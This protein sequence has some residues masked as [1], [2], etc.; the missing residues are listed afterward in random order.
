MKH[1]SRAKESGSS[2]IIRHDDCSSRIQ[3]ELHIVCVSCTRDV[4]ERIVEIVI[5]Q[6]FLELLNEIQNSAV[7]I[8]WRPRVI[9]KG[10]LCRNVAVVDLLRKDVLL[11]QKE[12]DGSIGKGSVVADRAEELQ[13]LGH[14]VRSF[15]FREGLIKLGEGSNENDSVHGIKAVDPFATFGSLTTDVVHFEFDTVDA[16]PFHDHLSGFD[17]SQKN[18]LLCGVEIV[19]SDSWKVL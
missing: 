17:T 4:N 11:V 12:H 18:V 1:L 13:R 16:V 2:K 8:F 7:E 10:F 5:N 15:G 6:T 9:C 3:N 14:S 19:G